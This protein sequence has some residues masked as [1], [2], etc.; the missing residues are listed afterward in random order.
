MTNQIKDES[1]QEKYNQLL[2]KAKNLHSYYANIIKNQ[3]E[4]EPLLFNYICIIRM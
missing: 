4:E 2:D 1:T 3:E